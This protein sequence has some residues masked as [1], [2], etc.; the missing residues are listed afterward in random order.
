[1]SAS[2]AVVGMSDE[3]E[4]CRNPR[5][6]ADEVETVDMAKVEVLAIRSLPRIA[7]YERRYWTAALECRE[8]LMKGMNEAS[9]SY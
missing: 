7:E 3:Y 9:F 8:I 6:E 1:M 5:R 2:E 4:R